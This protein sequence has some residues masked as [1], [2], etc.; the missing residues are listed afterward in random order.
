MNGFRGGYRPGARARAIRRPPGT[1]VA[2]R[3]GALIEVGDLFFGPPNVAVRRGGLLRWR[4]MGE[5]LH[6]VTLA[7]GPRGLSSPNLSREREFRY[8][9]REPG[10]YRLY[11]GLH[12]VSMT[13]TV[14]VERRR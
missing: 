9:F 4:F 2:L 6:N 13:S 14:R 5:N 12:P 1:T 7:N 11:C 10:T 3:S 8:R